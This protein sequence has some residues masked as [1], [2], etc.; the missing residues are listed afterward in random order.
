ML[1]SLVGISLPAQGK[2]PGGR[3]AALESDCTWRSFS[4]NLS[5]DKESLTWGKGG[6]GMGGKGI[7]FGGF[8]I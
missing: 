7:I 2:H 8:F 5:F 1:T 3:D 6:D 4:L